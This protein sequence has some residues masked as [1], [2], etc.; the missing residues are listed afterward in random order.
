MP[1]PDKYAYWQNLLS[2][3]QQEKV[4]HE[5]REVFAQSEHLVHIIQQQG[6]HAAL[7]GEIMDGTISQ[8]DKILA[9]K[10]IRKSA[11][12]LRGVSWAFGCPALQAV[13]VPSPSGGDFPA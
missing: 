2:Q 8:E 10:Q 9:E 1:T 4:L 5:L 11:S 6:S 13:Q 7:V 3:T 12:R